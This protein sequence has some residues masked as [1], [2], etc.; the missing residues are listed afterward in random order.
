MKTEKDLNKKL[1][2]IN[3]R[4]DKIE[5]TLAM[6]NATLAVLSSKMSPDPGIKPTW[7]PHWPP[8][9]L[10][11]PADPL[12]YFAPVKIARTTTSDRTTPYDWM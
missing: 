4:L 7:P 5:N 1:N 11:S 9:V 12:P 6:I 8:P 3:K 10:P 2:D